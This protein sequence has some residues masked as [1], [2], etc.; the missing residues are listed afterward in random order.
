MPFKKRG[1]LTTTPLSGEFVNSIKPE[2]K[3]EIDLNDWEHYQ[4]SKDFNYSSRFCQLQFDGC[5][6]T[7][8]PKIMSD[9]T[10]FKD[11]KVKDVYCCFHCEKIIRD[12][13]KL[14]SN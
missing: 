2:K 4:I 3:I 11:D 10:L 9:I 5:P 8:V 7:T 1:G 14:K 13:L 6:I 12:K